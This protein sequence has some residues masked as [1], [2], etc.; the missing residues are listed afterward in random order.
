MIKF[1]IDDN[2]KKRYENFLSCDLFKNQNKIS[3]TEYWKYHSKNIEINLKDNILKLKG[4]SGFYYSERNL[5]RELKKFIKKILN[6][7]YSNEVKYL[8]YK[9]A[10]NKQLKQSSYPKNKISLDHDSI[11][12]KNFT[13]IKKIPI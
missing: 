8:E 13:D 11:L 6:F 10:F 1:E 5:V 3:K 9:K 2:F 4:A 12:V 7:F